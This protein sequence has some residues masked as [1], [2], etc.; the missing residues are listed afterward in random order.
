MGRRLIA[1]LAGLGILAGCGGMSPIGRSG[2]APVFSAT[3]L[4]VQHCGTHGHHWQGLGLTDKQKEEIRAIIVKHRCGPQQTSQAMAELKAAMVAPTI[5]TAALTSA[6]NAKIT[7]RTAK[8]DAKVAML[9]DIRQVLTPEQRTKFAE[10]KG[11]R[12]KGAGKEA[13]KEHGQKHMDRLAEKLGLNKAQRQAF[14]D[15]RTA[16]GANKEAIKANRAARHQAIADF[17]KSGDTDALKAALMAIKPSVPVDAMVKA[18]ASLTQDQRKKLVEMKEQHR[19]KMC[20]RLTNP[21]HKSTLAQAS[22]ADEAQTNP[23]EDSQAEES[24]E[25]APQSPA[26]QADPP[27]D[28]EMETDD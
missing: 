8:V 10:K 27:A 28:T 23:A 16:Y 17:M 13:F 9:A 2:T 1:T 26:P 7:D 15:V 6:L 24:A 11:K 12:G 5:D 25:A 21:K 14:E 3:S 20:E 19:A 18:I 4:S 22:E